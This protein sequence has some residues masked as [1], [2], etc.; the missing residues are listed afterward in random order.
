MNLTL[1]G[2]ATGLEAF[3][4]ALTGSDG[5]TAANLWTAVTAVAGIIVIGV[6]FAFAYRMVKKVV[7]GISKGK[8]GM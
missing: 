7:K 1:F 3:I 8:A 4:T 2:D 6:L 5:I